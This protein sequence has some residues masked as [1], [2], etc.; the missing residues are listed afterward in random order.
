[1]W[2]WCAIKG[3]T[4]HHPSPA[5]SKPA[6]LGVD[7]GT[8]TLCHHNFNFTG[9]PT[10]III[11]LAPVIRLEITFM[12]VNNSPWQIIIIKTAAKRPGFT[13]R[14]RR[15]SC[16]WADFRTLPW[17]NLI[18]IIFT[19]PDSESFVKKIRVSVIQT[20]S[21]LLPRL[22]TNHRS[23]HVYGVADSTAYMPAAD[24]QQ[25]QQRPSASHRRTTP[26]L[27]GFQWND[28][29]FTG[30]YDEITDSAVQPYT[31]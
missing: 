6:Q 21:F 26:T 29:V 5:I 8:H 20:N 14:A 24:H 15:W 28:I 17:V 23:S 4:A 19:M 9:F 16:W 27:K 31:A 30:C 11:M 10:I 12:D 22:Q 18:V 2:K 7:G 25:R 1:M 13:L 3:R